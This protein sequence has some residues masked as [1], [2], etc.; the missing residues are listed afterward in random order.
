MYSLKIQGI[1]FVWFT[2]FF[3]NSIDQ[4]ILTNRGYAYILDNIIQIIE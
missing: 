3:Q 2:K 1:E 4:R